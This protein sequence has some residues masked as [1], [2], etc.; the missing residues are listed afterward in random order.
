MLTLLCNSIQALH[1]GTVDRV[2]RSVDVEDQIDTLISKQLHTLIVVLGVI[3]GVD[4]DGIETQLLE[5]GDV[6]LAVLGVCEGVL[7]RR[8]AA[9][10]Q[11]ISSSLAS[12]PV[13]C[14]YGLIVDATDVEALITLPEGI[15]L[16]GN[17][18][19]F[20]LALEEASEGSGSSES[21]GSHQ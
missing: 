19:D 8:V 17:R 13:T 20:R 15:A 18:R 1:T 16:D 7:G 9:L 10:C 6:T 12:L 21:D 3:D 4:T 2:L 5:V 11:R 14:T